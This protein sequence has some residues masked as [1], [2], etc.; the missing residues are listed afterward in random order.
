L[1]GGIEALLYVEETFQ[2]LA[3][4]LKY[5]ALDAFDSWE[6]CVGNSALDRWENINNA[7]DDP[8]DRT[9]PKFNNVIFKFYLR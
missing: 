5:S 8:A 4:K 1:R 6:L 2:K 7:G 9:E 3:K